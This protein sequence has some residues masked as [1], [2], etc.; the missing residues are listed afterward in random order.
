M[1][2]TKP[3]MVNWD[4]PMLD[5]FK[6]E[7]EKVRGGSDEV[8][9]FEGNE[10]VVGYAKY[11]IEY[12]EQK[13]KEAKSEPQPPDEKSDRDDNNPVEQTAEQWSETYARMDDYEGFIEHDHSMDN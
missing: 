8:F 6:M 13:L 12:L 7:Y 3:T 9:Q 11:L 4:R 5:R 2:S 10:Y 1:N